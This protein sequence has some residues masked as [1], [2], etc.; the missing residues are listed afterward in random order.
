[1]PNITLCYEIV[2]NGNNSNRVNSL[3]FKMRIFAQREKIC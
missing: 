2:V 1:M 3:Q